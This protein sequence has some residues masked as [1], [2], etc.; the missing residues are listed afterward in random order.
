[1]SYINFKMASAVAQGVYHI[2]DNIPLEDV[3]K[4]V[5]KENFKFFGVADGAGSAKYAKESAEIILSML[6]FELEINSIK[7][8]Q[9]KNIEASLKKYI[10]SVLYTYSI[11]NN[12]EFKELCST[13][14]AIAIFGEHY[15]QI[16]IG[17]GLL[18]SID[19]NNKLK[20]LSEPYHGRFANYT[21]FCNT[22]EQND[23]VRVKRGK[24]E[25]IKNGFLVCSDGIEDSLYD[26][27]TGKISEVV[28]DMIN[29]L[30]EYSEDEV[31]DI[32]EHNL[33]VH[34][35]EESGDD[36][37]IVIAKGFKDENI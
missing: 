23:R 26:S 30:D 11:L 27:A 24:T 25:D 10:E 20:L 8:L 37:S 22:V 12:I 13:L 31:S 19:N 36:L 3:V 21:V 4:L 16:H 15:I 7:Y 14:V 28:T 29:W 9:S 34:F 35:A 18:I 5:N 33:K 6:S 17:D 1:M 32:L 2:E